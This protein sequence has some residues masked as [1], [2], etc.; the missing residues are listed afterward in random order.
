MLVI[1]YCA[2]RLYYDTAPVCPAQES[3]YSEGPTQSTSMMTPSRSSTRVPR[4]IL[5]E[6]SIPSLDNASTEFPDS[7]D[8]DDATSKVSRPRSKRQ[9]VSDDEAEVS[10][11]GRRRSTTKTS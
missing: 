8:S 5:E 4:A 10:L 3:T 1:D 7:D 2:Q 6:A 11:D 9:F